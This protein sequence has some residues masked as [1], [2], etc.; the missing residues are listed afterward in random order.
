MRHIVSNY[1]CGC[2][3]IDLVMEDGEHTVFVEVRYR[4]SARYGGALASISR[5]K[6]AKLRRTAAHYLKRFDPRGTR[7]CR[8]DVLAPD[9]DNASEWTWIRNAF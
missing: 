3:E 5:G 9:P 4:A 7:P 8:F 2:G 1:R 6:I